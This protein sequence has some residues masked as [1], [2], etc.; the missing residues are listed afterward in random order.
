MGSNPS[1]PTMTFKNLLYS[2]VEFGDEE[3]VR[4]GRDSWYQRYGESL[5]PV[6][7]NVEAL[8]EIFMSTIIDTLYQQTKEESP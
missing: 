4:F 6:L 3:Y 8:E 7:Y 5:E 2:A 1:P